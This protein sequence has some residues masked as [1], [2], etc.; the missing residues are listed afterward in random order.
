MAKSRKP[1]APGSKAGDAGDPVGYCNPPKTHQFKPNQ[2]GNPG[3]SS[4]KVRA[5]KMDREN[6]PHDSM[7]LDES[8]RP[9]AITENGKRTQIPVIQ[10]VH[11]SAMIDAVKGDRSAQK[12]IIPQVQAAQERREAAARERFGLLVQYHTNQV[13]A[14]NSPTSPA[15]QDAQYWPHPDDV[16]LDYTRGSGEVV[17]PI[18]ARQAEAFAAL[19]DDHRLWHAR[20]T[21]L[22]DKASEAGDDVRDFYGNVTEAVRGLLDR[23][24]GSLPSSFKAQLNWESEAAAD[25]L[26]IEGLDRRIVNLALL[27][28]QGDEMAYCLY[29]LFTDARAASAGVPRRSRIDITANTTALINRLRIE[30]QAYDANMA[31]APAAPEFGDFYEGIAGESPGS[32]DEAAP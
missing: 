27:D 26:E 11:R 6:S 1:N 18:D 17:G 9:V 2:S 10:A 12:L 19:I 21:W 28:L 22:E 4:A 25:A 32:G 8:V 3:G 7:I 15:P 23:I 13:I 31:P 5:R 16:R 20:L 24:G 30:R 29:Q 14:R